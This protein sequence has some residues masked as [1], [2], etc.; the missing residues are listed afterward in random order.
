M[1]KITLKV[2][3]LHP[4]AVIPKYATEGSSGM[5]LVAIENTTINVFE[6]KLI[7][8]GLSFALPK[9]TELQVRPRSGL[10]LKTGLT[11]RNAPGTVDED[12]IG[13]VCIIMSLFPDGKGTVSYEIRKGDRIAQ[14]VLCPVLK[15]IIEEVQYLDET[16]RGA[17]GFGST[18]K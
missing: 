4:D 14:I 15:P 5:D 9:N 16:V 18:G 12:F 8:T 3:K 17:G 10:S 2:K 6:T 1:S 13:Q 7:P 11:I